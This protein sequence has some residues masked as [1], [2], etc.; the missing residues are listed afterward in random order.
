MA[1]KELYKYMCRWCGHKFEQEVGEAGDH[2]SKV[3][4]QVKCKR[5]GN[6]LKTWGGKK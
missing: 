1:D 2:H 3:V 6:F 4:T 5:C